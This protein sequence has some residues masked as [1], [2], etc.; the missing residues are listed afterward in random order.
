MKDHSSLLVEIP[1]ETNPHT[2]NTSTT[3]SEVPEEKQTTTESNPKKANKFLQKAKSKAIDISEHEMS[4]EKVCQSYGSHFNVEHPDKSQGLT[5]EVAEERLR[6]NGPNALSPPKKRPFIFKVIEQ[7]TSLF[8]LL[9]IV[10]GLLSF[11]D[12]AIERTTDSLPNLFL[13]AILWLVVIFNATVTLWQERSSEKILESFMQMQSESSWVLRDG[14]TLKLPCEQLVLGDIVKIEAGDKIPADM[15][16]LQ[17]SALKL[18]NSSLTG[19]AEP[20]LRSVEMS[21]KNPLET[22]NLVF[23]GTLVI[24]GS[25]Y[26]IVIRCGNQSVIGQIALLAGSTITLK[27]PLRREIDSFVR[28]IGILAF[29]MALMFFVLG[30]IIGNSWFQNFIF[31]IGIITANIPQGLIA[32]V[33]ACLTVSASRLKAVNVL[34]KK[35]EHVETLG[36]TS[37]ICSD[38]TGT[39]TQNRMTLVEMWYDNIMQN[40]QYPNRLMMNK[41]TDTPLKTFSKESEEQLSTYEKLTRCAALCSTAY[42][43]NDDTN[44]RKPILDRECKGDASEAALVKFVETRNDCATLKEIRQ[45]FT[46]I[47]ALPFNSKNKYM[48][49]VVKNN[50]QQSND[51]K[52]TLLMKG[53]PERVFQR[54]SYIQVNGKTLP[55]DDTWK[56]AFQDAYNFMASK[57]ERVLGFAQALVDEHVVQQGKEQQENDNPFALQLEGL[58]F[59]GICGLSDPPKVGVTE[60]IHKCKTAGIQVVMVTGDHPATAKA[61]AKQVGIIENNAKTI[62]DIAE[63]EGL[64]LKNIKEIPYSRT[65]AVVLHGEEIDK[66]SDKD[67]SQILKK[68]QI[69]FSRTS[70]QQKLLIVSKFQELGHCVAVTGD[71]TNDSPALKKADIGVAMNI[72]GTCGCCFT[73]L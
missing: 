20:Q 65:D 60:A 24:E 19:E 22:S 54:C 33:T 26:G 3:T 64:D 10:A 27:A 15:R 4:V 34:V 5:S 32:T 14:I 35:L 66:L 48:I 23:Y 61:I 73:C 2:C 21:S 71:G 44:M 50:Q 42:L 51:G 13:G 59:L 63:E 68:K 53:A 38:K 12:V 41:L 39:I 11:I 52:V 46:E 7:L 30:F 72:S 47:F 56:D 31:A 25:G 9:L 16:V 36:S 43:L 28:K 57:G 58:V 55:M 45:E 69:V 40:I 70:P 49:S 1:L 37:V 18:D 62:E 6:M 8:S 67:W 17:C 29:G